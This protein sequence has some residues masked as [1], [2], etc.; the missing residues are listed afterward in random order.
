VINTSRGIPLPLFTKLEVRYAGALNVLFPLLRP[1]AFAR[2][3]VMV[4]SLLSNHRE[5]FFMSLGVAS[6]NA[7]SLRSSSTSTSVDAN[8][9]EEDEPERIGSFI[10]GFAKYGPQDYFGEVNNTMQI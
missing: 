1:Y 7:V 10:N 3:D 4:S 5:M 6:V 2:H 9:G 8:G